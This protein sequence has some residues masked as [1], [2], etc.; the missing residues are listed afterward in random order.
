MPELTKNLVY[1][2]KSVTSLHISLQKWP[3]KAS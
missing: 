1:V 3:N 2:I